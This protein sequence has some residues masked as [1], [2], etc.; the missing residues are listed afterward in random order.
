MTRSIGPPSTSTQSCSA[1]WLTQ[2]L[3][4]RRPAALARGRVAQPVHQLHG[5]LGAAVMRNDQHCQYLL[6][7]LVAP[8]LGLV[9]WAEDDVPAGAPLDGVAGGRAPQPV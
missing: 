7:L 1:W 4:L 3:R 9:L 6:R 2:G 8:V 5:G